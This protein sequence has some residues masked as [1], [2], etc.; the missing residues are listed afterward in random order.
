MDD[1][2][3]IKQLPNAALLEK[4]VLSCLLQRP[5]ELMDEF[6]ELG[7]AADDF[8]NPAHRQLFEHIRK[9]LAQGGDF[10]LVKF[11]QRAMENGIAAKM[12]GPEFITEIYCYSPNTYH[13]PQH[14]REIA[15]RS[16][17]RALITKASDIIGMAHDLNG[18]HDASVIAD[19][20]EKSILDARGSRDNESHT[21]TIKELLRRAVG[22]YEQ[23]VTSGETDAFGYKT[24]FP[25]FDYMTGGLK[26]GNL[27][28][29]AARPSMGKTTLMCNM[30]EQL[31]SENK[32]PC[33]FY[34]L[35]MSQDAVT[36]RMISQAS[37][38]NLSEIM[39][40]EL[41]KGSM[42]AISSSMQAYESAPITVIDK[43]GITATQIRT[44]TRR[45]C[46]NN[47]VKAVFIDYLQ[48]LG[49]EDRI[50]RT[51]D[52]VLC[53][54]ALKNLK[55]LAKECS[56]PVVLLAQLNRSADGIPA[57]RHNFSHL[58]DCG[59][60]EQDADVIMTIGR[61]EEE[62]DEDQQVVKRTLN[63]LKQ[64]NGATGTIPINF[65]KEATR[66]YE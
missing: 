64:R 42:R 47:G 56:I 61:P 38:I 53:K 15:D 49:A 30:L 3:H 12:G 65:L 41:T 25:T 9:T 31:G 51:D 29:I 6:D 55:E 54:N 19:I 27:Y 33:D 48:I 23:A 11:T 43:A 17:R 34:S 59:N 14:C 58:K 22:R 60:I 20:A 52:R 10:D 5:D 40:G 13:F 46:K 57:S 8:Y 7:M 63:I 24:G 66:F 44:K 2:D 36:D 37:R 28:I 39:K 35:E 4:S 26:A 50:E 62:Q 18:D 21:Y 32:H 1:N 45:R 16:L